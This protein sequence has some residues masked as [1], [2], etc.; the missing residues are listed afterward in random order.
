MLPLGPSLVHSQRR[1]FRFTRY[2]HGVRSEPLSV[3]QMQLI[4]GLP[5]RQAVRRGRFLPGTRL[6]CLSRS[7]PNT[8]ESADR[9]DPTQ[10]AANNVHPLSLAEPRPMQSAPSKPSCAAARSSATRPST[11][12]AATIPASTTIP[13]RTMAHTA[14]RRDRMLALITGIA[15]SWSTVGR[16]RGRPPGRPISGP[17]GA[18]AGSMQGVAG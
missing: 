16:P 15:G 14:D 18:R 6:L 17:N 13:M 3:A 1:A 11:I 5:A 7:A 4:L 10:A 9:Q 8:R 2:E 12:R